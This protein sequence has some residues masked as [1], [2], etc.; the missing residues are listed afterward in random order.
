MLKRLK[1]N[2]RSIKRAKIKVKTKTDEMRQRGM[3]MTMMVGMTT[4]LLVSRRERNGNVASTK[5]RVMTHSNNSS[6]SSL[7]ANDDDDADSR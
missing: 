5:G 2:T 1:R 3:R 7:L 6:Q 4:T